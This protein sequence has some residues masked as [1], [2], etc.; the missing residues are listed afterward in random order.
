MKQAKPMQQATN[1]WEVNTYCMWGFVGANQPKL[2][3]MIHN[4][5]NVPTEKIKSKVIW[6]GWN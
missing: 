3:G 5:L 2:I 4:W 1:V 6:A